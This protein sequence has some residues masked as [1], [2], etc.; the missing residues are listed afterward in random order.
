MIN[1]NQVKVRRMVAQD[2]EQIAQAFSHMHKTL[3]QYEQY[4]QENVHSQRVTLIAEFE[5][6]IVGYTNI[7]WQSDYESFRS[8]GIPEISDMNVVAHLRRNGIGTKM[9]EAAEQVVRQN[10]KLVIGIGVGATP[11]YG[12][13]QQLYPKLGYVSDGTGIHTDEWGGAMYSTKKIG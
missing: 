1:P 8:Q 5:G 12:I 4:W 7:V 11:D 10:G 9:V 13:A 3:E 6:C 2:V